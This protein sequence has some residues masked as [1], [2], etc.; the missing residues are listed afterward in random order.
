MR[1]KSRR[2]YLT[3]L[4]N[5]KHFD[6]ALID[7]V[8]SARSREESLSLLMI[9]FDHFKSFNDTYEHATGDQVLRLVAM[10]LRQTLKGQHVA[11]RYGGRSSRFS[12]RKLHTMRPHGR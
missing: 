6:E 10:S 12:F 11:A 1:M 9:D 3:E 5:R 4:S 7:A 2:D 8:R